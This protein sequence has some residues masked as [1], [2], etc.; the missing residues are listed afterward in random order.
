[1]LD[2]G[3]IEHRVL[4]SD[5]D[6]MRCVAVSDARDGE[7]CEVLFE[8]DH[9]SFV[10]ADAEAVVRAWTEVGFR[11]EPIFDPAPRDASAALARVLPGLR[12][13]REGLVDRVVH[14]EPDAWRERL[15]R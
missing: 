11:R 9:A 6:C 4:S 1:M 3:A 8:A 10:L 15:F 7:L 13:A 5:D 14:T 2:A 12:A